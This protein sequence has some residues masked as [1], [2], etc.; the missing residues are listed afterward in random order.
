MSLT[1][2][3][4]EDTNRRE[5]ECGGK[6]G[7]KN[8]TAYRRDSSRCSYLKINLPRNGTTSFSANVL[9]H[10]VRATKISTYFLIARPCIFLL[11]ALGHEHSR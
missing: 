5:A 1:R 3:E 7:G 11:V 10:H 6:K 2:K 8:E 4:E 9:S